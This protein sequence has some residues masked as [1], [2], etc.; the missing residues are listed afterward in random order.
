MLTANQ[1]ATGTGGFQGYW[2][3]ATRGLS[4]GPAGFNRAVNLCC[5]HDAAQAHAVR[6]LHRAVSLSRHTPPVA[7]HTAGASDRIPRPSGG[8]A[9]R[10]SHIAAAGRDM[11]APARRAPERRRHTPEA[12]RH[13][14]EPSGCAPEPSRR[15]PEPSRC[16]GFGPKQA[17]ILEK[18][19]FFLPNHNQ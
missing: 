17:K 12:W 5:P 4:P 3:P 18:H 19:T 10:F 6:F 1:V 2:T 14:S 8:A 7:G 13:P 16:A 15:A 9:G 11:P